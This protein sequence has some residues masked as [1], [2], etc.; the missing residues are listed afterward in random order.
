MESIISNGHESR[1]ALR[2]ATGRADTAHRPKRLP[3]INKEKTVS[4]QRS[5]DGQ[6]L[7]VGFWRNRRQ[8]TEVIFFTS[9]GDGFQVF[10]ISTVGDADLNDLA[11]GN[12][13]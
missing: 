10:G 11:E 13:I 2:Y 9:V 7:G 6:I 1:S 3:A 4:A 12:T 5:T 8:V